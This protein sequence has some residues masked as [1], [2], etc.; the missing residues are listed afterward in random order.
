MAIFAIE[1]YNLSDIFRAL[2]KDYQIVSTI[3]NWQKI[4][5]IRISPNVYTS[6][7]ELDVLVDAIRELAK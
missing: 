1:G 7:E 4:A 6:L 3:S 2:R 5:G